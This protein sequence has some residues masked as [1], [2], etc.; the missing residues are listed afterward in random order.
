MEGQPLIPK[1]VTAM[2]DN[3]MT[4]IELTG[5]DIQ[6]MMMGAFEP[7]V[8]RRVAP[9]HTAKCIDGEVWE[10]VDDQERVVSTINPTTVFSG[11]EL[12]NRLEKITAG[13]SRMEGNFYSLPPSP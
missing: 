5:T 11:L 3:T 1:T 8:M 4:H 10:V 2:M 9:G 6:G 7:G 13:K 12:V